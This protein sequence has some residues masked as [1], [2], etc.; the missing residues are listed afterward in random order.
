MRCI[1]IIEIIHPS[2][3]SF[4]IKISSI[5]YLK[6]FKYSFNDLIWQSYYISKPPTYSFNSIISYFSFIYLKWFLKKTSFNYLFVCPW[7]N[8]IDSFNIFNYS[9]KSSSMN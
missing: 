8:Y 5:S 1:L 2:K 7:V 9:Y 6:F 3:Y 4:S